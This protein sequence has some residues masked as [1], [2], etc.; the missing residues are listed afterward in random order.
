[1]KQ[2]F[3]RAFRRLQIARTISALEQ[4]SDSTLRDIGISRPGIKGYVHA[5]YE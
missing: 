1:M 2:I 5:M 4:C 3:A